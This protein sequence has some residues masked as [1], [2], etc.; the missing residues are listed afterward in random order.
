MVERTVLARILPLAID[1]CEGVAQRTAREGVP[2]IATGIGDAR[3]V[4][5]QQAETIRKPVA[6]NPGDR[7]PNALRKMRMVVNRGLDIITGRAIAA[8]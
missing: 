1:W 7:I 8:R 4:G 6:V 5:V 3:A 2:L